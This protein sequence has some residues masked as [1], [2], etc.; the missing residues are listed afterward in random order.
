MSTEGKG[1]KVT[2]VDLDSGEEETCEIKD[3]FVIVTDGDC[4]V[5]YVTNHA[6]GTVQMTIRRPSK[7]VKH[8][9]I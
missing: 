7:A 9:E 5:S 4:Y 1:T 8:I 2:S 6:S 3:D